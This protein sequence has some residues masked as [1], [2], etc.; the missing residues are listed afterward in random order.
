M[1]DPWPIN[2]TTPEQSRAAGWQAES[3]DADGHL[4]THHAPFD[5]PEDLAAYVMEEAARGHTVTVWPATP[6][7]LPRSI[8]E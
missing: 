4:M 8:G 7:A 1:R 2:L 6:A 5:G 3:R